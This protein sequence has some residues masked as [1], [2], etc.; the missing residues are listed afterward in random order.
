M[1]VSCV[2]VYLEV[3]VVSSCVQRVSV[4]VWTN[5]F[6]VVIGRLL[7]KRTQDFS[8]KFDNYTQYL[9]TD[10]CLGGDILDFHEK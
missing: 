6:P 10:M 2:C 5:V 1:V 8:W 4:S 7:R 3:F 9:P